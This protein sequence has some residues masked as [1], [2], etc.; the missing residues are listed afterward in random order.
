[1]LLIVNSVA[2]T[3][4]SRTKWYGTKRYGQNDMDK[5][6]RTKWYGQ[7]GMDKLVLFSTHGFYVDEINHKDSD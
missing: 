6:A 5:M 4:G 3:L 1:M 2:Y 7:N